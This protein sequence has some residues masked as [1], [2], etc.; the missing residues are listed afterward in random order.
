MAKEHS[1]A[2]PFPTHM[3]E[4]VH[5]DNC[6]VQRPCFWMDD[7]LFLGG[8]KDVREKIRVKSWF[9]KYINKEH[10]GWGEH[11][12]KGTKYNSVKCSEVIILLLFSF[13]NVGGTLLEKK[14]GRRKMHCGP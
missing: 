10:K 11:T 2:L 1:R 3:D 5:V 6:G 8:K 14:G 7:G 4:T 13:H 9:K 12:S